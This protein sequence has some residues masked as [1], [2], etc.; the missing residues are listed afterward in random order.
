MAKAGPSKLV[1]LEALRGIAAAVVLLH[2]FLLQFAP[3]L[4]GRNFPDDPI[5][6]VRTPLYALVHGSAAVAVFFVLSG[7]VL[8]VRALENRDWKQILVG[9]AKRWPRLVPLVVAVNV[10]SAIFFLLGLYG[11]STWFNIRTDPG[12]SAFEQ[13]ITVIGRA[14]KEG[15]FSTFVSGATDFNSALWTMHYE[16]IGSFAAYATALVLIFQRSFWGAMA[17]GAIAVLLTA[18]CSGE[19][20][21]YYA[22]PVAGVLLARIYLERMALAGTTASLKPWRAAVALSVAA[23][24]IILFGYD[25]YSKP[26]GFYAFAAP[27]SSPQAEP[28]IHGIAAA[29][30]LALVLFYDPV[31]RSLRGT[32]A[33]LLGRLSFPIYLVHLPILHGLVA[34]THA[35]LVARFDSA[36]AAP[37]AFALFITL[38]LLAAYP[39]ALLDEAWVRHLRDMAGL[40][41]AKLQRAK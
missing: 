2:H 16:L 33:A 14:L 9:V 29:A 31:R 20:G 13:A 4:H 39:L 6:L 30:L 15:L 27:I 40:L 28:L 12:A 8:T 11:N 22:M 7:F 5:A 25:G 21:V 18:L 19:G 23:M 41:T 17:T 32:T 35:V 37:A 34:P 3:R 26:T 36:V 10:L 24:T 38:T 1:E